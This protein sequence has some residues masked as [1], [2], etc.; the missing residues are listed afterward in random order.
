VL[1]FTG[2]KSGP[3]VSVKPGAVVVKQKITF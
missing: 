1:L 3:V 2:R